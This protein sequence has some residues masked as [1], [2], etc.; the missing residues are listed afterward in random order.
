MGIFARIRGLLGRSLENPSVPLSEDPPEWLLDA[1][2]A[3]ANPSG[4]SVTSR[5]AVRSSPVYGCVRIIAETAGTLPVRVYRVTAGRDL[6]PVY[7][8]RVA[9]LLRR[10][11]EAH[12][13]QVYR[14]QAIR[15]HILHGNA[16]TEIVRD[17]SGELRELWPL[18]PASTR[19]ILRD[20]KLHFETGG[21]GRTRVLWPS[22]VLHVPLLPDVGTI[23]GNAPP[24]LGRVAIGLGLAAET[25]GA[26]VFGD[27][28]MPPAVLEFP[29]RLDDEQFTRLKKRYRE[30]RK[31]AGSDALILEGGVKYQEQKV[32]HDKAQY[33]ETR[34]L[35]VLEVAR[36]FG[37]PPYLLGVEQSG[38][39]SS[40][41]EQERDFVRH[42][43]RPL[44]RRFER[45]YAR[46][47]FVGEAEHAVRHDTRELLQ[48]DTKTVWETYSK[49]RQFGI[50][51]ANDVRRDLGLEP[52]RGG[53]VYNVPVNLA[54]AR[55][56]ELALD[57]ALGHAG[58]SLASAERRAYFEDPRRDLFDDSR[59]RLISETIRAAGETVATEI[60]GPAGIS[61]SR[62]RWAAYAEALAAKHCEDGA[63]AFERNA[64]DWISAGRLDYDAEAA[65]AALVNGGANDGGDSER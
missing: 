29:N 34:K 30:A 53:D 12:E 11:N 47:L 46:K 37:V 42:T 44:L 60:L 52:I 28:L 21:G 3:T 59:R 51:S 24:I 39:R 14:E 32:E 38:P 50:Y 61:T 63:A 26:R 55:I 17:G 4:A 6:R 22:E 56:A 58:D 45:E 62:E 25:Y 10:P 48:A 27:G 1:F 16:Y 35:Q 43:L 5:T 18:D 65:A 9:W 2:G 64:L 20:R 7:G 57:A 41:E 40:V 54:E 15:T 31:N 33:L 13:G 36:F 23:T 19:P 8:H 49:G